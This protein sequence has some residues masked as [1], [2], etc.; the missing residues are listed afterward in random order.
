VRTALGA[1]RVRL[2]RQLF[3]ESILIAGIGAALG[4]L[5]AS[6]PS[7]FL[8]SFLNTSCNAFFLDLRFDWRVLMFTILLAGLTTVLFGL[9]PLVRATSASPQAAINAGGRSQMAGRD[10]LGFRRVLVASRIA[11]SLALLAGPSFFPAVF[12]RTNCVARIR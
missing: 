9:T 6:V 2:I 4:L 1:S 10:K 8:I 5:L 7:Q 12:T 3:A 11:V